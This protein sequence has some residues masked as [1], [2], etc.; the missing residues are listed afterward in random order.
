V[1]NR[2]RSFFA[3]LH[4]VAWSQA[5][6]RRDAIH[7][8]GVELGLLAALTASL[9]MA[10]APQGRGEDIA[11]MTR[12]EMS[13]EAFARLTAGMDPA[14]LALASRMTPQFGPQAQDPAA[15]VTPASLDTTGLQSA[16]LRL[17][18]MTPDEARAWNASNPTS[19]LPNPPAKPFRLKTGGMLDEARAVDCMTAAIYYEARWE[20]L[21]GQRA[22]AQVVLNRMR[23]PAYPKTV[24]GVVFQ[25]SNQ[26]TGCQFS[27]SCDGSM[28]GQPNPEVW[29]RCRTVA[30]AALDGYVMKAVG[31]ATHYHAVYVAPYWSPNLVKVSTIGAHIFY[32][33][34][35]GWG[36]P[37]AFSGH[38]EGSELAGM[39]LASLDK[40]APSSKLDVTGQVKIAASEVSPTI[41]AADQAGKPADARSPA[42]HDQAEPL[43][44][45][46]VAA[47]PLKAEELD[48]AGRPKKRDNH[49][50]LPE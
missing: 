42:G 44:T 43:T 37:P 26:T 10:A 35:G 11:K 14:M 50:A 33:W 7:L 34:T 24:C 25:G 19:T 18:D 32:R 15:T 45:L 16:V 39:Q 8:V 27:F 5:A 4:Q 13:A 28:R 12:G 17:Q 40:V 30:E 3:H 9:A 2:V 49:L 21:D 20:S 47:K 36:Q 31:N 22:V 48:W 23:H 6:W 41:E 1:L 38:Y 29:A 46:T